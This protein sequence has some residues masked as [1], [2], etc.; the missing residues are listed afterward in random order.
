MC[1]VLALCAAY[2]QD[3]HMAC[4]PSKVARR[5]TTNV[6]LKRQQPTVLLMHASS[7]VEGRD[8]VAYAHAY[9]TP[10]THEASAGPVQY[11]YST[12]YAC[13]VHVRH[14][15]YA[16]LVQATAVRYDPPCTNKRSKLSVS[17]VG[18]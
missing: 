5:K 12:Q 7:I 4:R 17:P 2:A 15:K 9:T 10:S 18:G 3:T 11:T 1:S 14:S 13:N 16:R 8:V 6:A